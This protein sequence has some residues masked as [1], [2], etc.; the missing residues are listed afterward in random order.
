[1]FRGIAA[2]LTLELVE[3]QDD[4]VELSMTFPR[5]PGLSADVWVCLQN[6]DE[7]WFC[8]EGIT[9]SRFPFPRCRP[10]FEATL[11]GVLSGHHR[12]LLWPGPPGRPAR[13]GEIQRPTETGWETVARYGSFPG[14]FRK[15]SAPDPQVVVLTDETPGGT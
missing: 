4:P 15:G 13:R 11:R 5:Q 6:V 1:M 9:Y 12:L 10:D 8:V 7:V 2:D 14:M 3:T